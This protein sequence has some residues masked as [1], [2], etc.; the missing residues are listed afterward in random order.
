MF[1]KNWGTILLRNFRLTRDF[2]GLATAPFGSSVDASS[3]LARRTF[4][5]GRNGSGKST[6]S[7]LLR[8]VGDGKLDRSQLP[9]SYWDGASV[10]SGTLP[11]PVVDAIHVYNRFYVEDSLRLFLDGQGISAGILKLGSHNVAAEAKLR[12]T[13][14]DLE[15]A[16]LRLKRLREKESELQKAK[17]AAEEAVKKAVIQELSAVDPVA[18]NTQA[19]NISKAR[20]LLGRSD[21]SELPLSELQTQRTLA[22]TED[23]KRLAD[24]RDLAVDLNGLG[25]QVA[26]LAKRQVVSDVIEALRTDLQASQWVESGMR[27]HDAG[28]ECRFCEHGVVTEER[29]QRLARHFDA[30]V[31]TLRADLGALRAKLDE[32]VSTIDAWTENLSSSDQ[33]L[34]ADRPNYEFEVAELN[35]GCG[36]LKRWIERAMTV[37]GARETRLLELAN[38]PQDVALVPPRVQVDNLRK[39]VSSH[40]EACGRQSA[41]RGLARRKLEEHCAFGH[42]CE[43]ESSI[44]RSKLAAR[45]IVRL[46]RRVATL[47]QLERDLMA[48]QQD[49]GHMA[50]LL[51]EDLRD[52]FGHAHLSI[53]VSDD[54]KGYLVERNNAPAT[55]LSEGERNSI[56]LLYF[57]RG[58]EADHLSI[59]ND[60]VVIDDP[61]TSLDKEALFAAHAVIDQ[62]TQDVGQIIILTH[63]FEYLRLNLNTYKS[64]FGKSQK[65]IREGVASEIGLPS[66]QFLEVFARA[67]SQDA[68]RK[69]SLRTLSARLL[70]HPSEYH[71]LFWRIASALIHHEDAELPLLGNAGR[72]LLEGFI[73]FK[74]PNGGDFQQKIEMTAKTA[75]ASAE[76]MQRVLR[77][78][79]GAS[80]RGEPNLTTALDFPSIREEL[81]ELFSFMRNCDA[82]HFD[83]MSKSVEVDLHDVVA[84]H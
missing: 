8:Q 80:H 34:P 76:Q 48:S 17:S 52:H 63:D 24:V 2:R 28:D 7:E 29:L 47:E 13:R 22:K 64:A 32:T 71:Y 38:V 83:R 10:R 50:A 42:Q 84:G 77:F 81:S 9:A 31:M 70:T 23:L 30:S 16:R 33:V 82:D 73:S 56:A 67:A 78:A 60:L 65:K 40:N 25:G 1:L 19:F 5:Y 55:D 41:D 68:E 20:A 36:D 58:L 11:Q 53:A 12:E 62:R 37:I 49:T 69:S 74:A 39:I 44:V 59:E 45:A 15:V 3:C 35:A 51:N 61:V 79:H 46:Q 26:E 75:G 21:I 57:L 6:F 54:N 27:L 18:Y 72:R 14:L 66:V 4:I 43:Y